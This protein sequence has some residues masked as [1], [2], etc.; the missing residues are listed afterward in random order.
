MPK[1]EEKTNHNIP[2]S[3]YKISQNFKQEVQVDKPKPI[4][5]DYALLSNI[6]LK[7]IYSSSKNSGWIIISEKSSSKTHMLGIGDKFKSYEL[8]QIFDRYVIF[9]KNNQEYK[10]TLSKEMEIKTTKVEEKKKSKNNNTSNFEVTR[11][12]I[13]SYV[14]DF[15]KIWK[16]IAIKEYKRDGKIIGFKVYGLSKNSIF[17][18]LGLK[19][20]DIIT[21]VNNVELKTYQ[22]AFDIYKN[23]EYID[24]VQISILRK[25]KPME[26]EYEI[27]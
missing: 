22:D 13:N 23:I 16:H 5:K 9:S 20:G 21:S 8:K 4:K 7:A 15:D 12:I 26:L 25:N 11:E 18:E 10:V 2:Y 27:K 19:K 14:K 24:D 3:K 1:V 6:I 17:K